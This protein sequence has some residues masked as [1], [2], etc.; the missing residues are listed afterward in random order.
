[1]QTPVSN[2]KEINLQ[3]LPQALLRAA[4]NARKLAGQTGTL[5]A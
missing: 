3:M 4:E 2:L 5:L 1:M